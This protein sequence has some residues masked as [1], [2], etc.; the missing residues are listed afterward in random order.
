MLLSGFFL[1]SED[2][3]ARIGYGVS[4]QVIKILKSSNADI[5]SLQEVDINCKRSKNRNCGM[6]FTLASYTSVIL[7]LYQLECL[8]LHAVHYIDMEIS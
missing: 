6:V 2:T 8:L 5:I 3:Y 4:L 7:Y 1:Y